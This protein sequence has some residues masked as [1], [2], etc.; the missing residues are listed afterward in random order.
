MSSDR[1]SFLCS[2][3]GVLSA[4]S[5]LTG[6]VS[7]A[8][9]LTGVVS[10]RGH[11]EAD[12]FGDGVRL[13]SGIGERDFERQGTIPGLDE[14]ADDI[15]VFAHGLGASKRVARNTFENSAT[16]LR[17][18]AADVPVVGFS[19]DSN[20]GTSSGQNGVIARRNGPKL[21]SFCQQL[22]EES[23]DTR[24]HLVGYSLGGYVVMSTLEFLEANDAGITIDTVHMLGGAPNVDSVTTDGRYGP[25][26]ERA[27]G[28]VYNFHKTNDL[29]LGFF[30]FFGEPSVGRVGVDTE[31][32]PA[33]VT[34]VDV[35]DDVDWHT[36]YPEP[37][38]G[39]MDQV[40]GRL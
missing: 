30:N 36:T 39:C 3:A 20:E 21:G 34:N 23:P 1:R 25:G 17:A 15:L 11:F 2:C 28:S 24:I 4:G 29:V 32:A 27:A 14:A 8:S 5:V 26:I 18:A 9:E 7:A 35:T 16:A 31:R 37:D 22:R 10:T 13:A 38:G 6:S 12:F 19:Y 33:N 40:A